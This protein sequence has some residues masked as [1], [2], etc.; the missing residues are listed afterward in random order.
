MNSIIRI[1]SVLMM[2]VSVIGFFIL[3]VQA[4]K[5]MDGIPLNI[6]E[7]ADKAMPH[8]VRFDA[9]YNSGNVYLKWLV[10]G[11]TASCIY[12][13]E[14]SLTGNDDFRIIDTK[15]GIG[16][17]PEPVIMY[18]YTDTLPTK[19]IAY[20]RIKRISADWKISVTE[21]VRVEASGRIEEIPEIISGVTY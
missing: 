16:T 12:L 1:L 17:A 9:I 20:Y 7:N 19:G 15:E 3:P 21:P 18:C 8:L 5:N 14:R 11:Q 4:Q 2:L 6:N 10:Q 13:V